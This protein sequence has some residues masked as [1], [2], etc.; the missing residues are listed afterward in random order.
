MSRF[1]VFEPNDQAIRDR[2]LGIVN[3]YLEQ[4]RAERGL[5]AFQVRMDNTNNTSADIDAG[6][7]NGQLFLQPTRTAE[8]IVL[9]FTIQATGAAFPE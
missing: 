8:F 9:D 1:L 2:F 6:I 4:V 5:T 3:P 7:L